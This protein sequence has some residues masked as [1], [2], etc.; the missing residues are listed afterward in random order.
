MTSA[1]SHTVS[2]IIVNYNGASLLPACIESALPTL[3]PGSEL[4]VVDNASTDDSRAVL[5]RYGDAVRLASSPRNVGFGR[6][7]NLG[8]AVARGDL[9]VFLNP[10]VTFPPGWLEPLIAAAWSDMR[11]GPLCPLPL[12]PGA[13]PPDPSEPALEEHAMLPGCCLAFRRDAWLAIGGFDQAFFLY[14]EDTELCWRAWLLGWRAVAVRT[15][16]VYHQKGATTGA[17]GR[18]D[19]E[20]ARNSLYTYLKLMRWPVVLA[21]IARLL[22]VCAVKSVRWPR[23]APDLARAWGW[24]IAHLPATLRARRMI[25]ARR[26]GDYRRLEGM[27]RSDMA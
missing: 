22:I 3:P 25:Q 5:A 23:L 20:R 1:A 6:A 8:A 7:C 12:P 11:I 4:L 10:D 18:W 13:P 2:L 9:L 21:Y 24:N 15:S 19:A 14:W 17:F 16:W 26:A 27:I